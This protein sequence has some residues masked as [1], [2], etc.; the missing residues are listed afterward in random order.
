MFVND[1]H[2]CTPADKL[3]S[4]TYTM[5][6]SGILPVPGASLAKLAEMRK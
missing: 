6:F 2:G 3:R 5:E 4:R 1:M